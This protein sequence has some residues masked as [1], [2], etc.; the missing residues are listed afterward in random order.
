MSGHF[1]GLSNTPW[2]WIGLFL[3]MN[4]MWIYSPVPAPTPSFPFYLNQILLGHSAFPSR[5]TQLIMCETWLGGE[6]RRMVSK[7][8]PWRRSLSPPHL[9]RCVVFGSL[10][11][12]KATKRHVR[13]KLHF[14]CKAFWYS[15]TTDVS[16][17]MY[18]NRL[19]LGC[20]HEPIHSRSPS[21]LQLL[22]LNYNEPPMAWL[23]DDNHSAVGHTQYKQL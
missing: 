1:E 16:I 22:W 13:A 15:D 12:S 23:G 3:Q 11:I 10:K 8:I 2:W 9:I 5:G 20:L 18:R 21:W 14:Y 4:F 17:I 19:L 6:Q 7:D